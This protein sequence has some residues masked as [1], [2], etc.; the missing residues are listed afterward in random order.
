MISMPH[1]G[2]TLPPLA[3]PSLLN[4]R[5]ISESSDHEV[6]SVRRKVGCMEP[7]CSRVDSV[8]KIWPWS[9]CEVKAMTGINIRTLK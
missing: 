3:A 1:I 4:F 6:L 7:I 5:F 2:I 9:R 8:T